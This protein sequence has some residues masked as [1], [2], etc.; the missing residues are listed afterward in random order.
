MVHPR[1]FLR[2]AFCAVLLAGAAGCS[3]KTIVAVDPFP[4]SDGGNITG[5]GPGLLDDLIGFWRLNEPPGSTVAHD[6]SSWGNDGTLVGL[7]AATVWVDD[8]PEGVALNVAGK[9]HVEVPASSSIN[10][11]TTQVT[12][13]AWMYIDGTIGD[14]ATAISRQIAGGFSQHYYLAVNPTLQPI[15]YITVGPNQDTLPRFA[16]ATATQKTWFH[17]AVT[18]DGSNVA[19]YLNGTQVDG[20]TLTGQFVPETNP[21]ILAGNGNGGSVTESVPGRLADVMLYRRALPARDI[22]RIYQGAL[23]LPKHRDASAEH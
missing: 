3:P 6:S 2:A 7:D 1:S 12:L 8:G 11:I 9:G 5:C 21:V 18:Y 16:S 22:K 10:S 23:L 20:G 17:L 19:L 13:A 15:T 14:F 4:C